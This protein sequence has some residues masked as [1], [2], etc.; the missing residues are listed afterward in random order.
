MALTSAEV[1][2]CNQSLGKIGAKRFT[3]GD[4][5]SNQSIQCLLHFE[6]NRDALLRTFK[7]P[8]AKTRLRLVSAWLTDT[9][10][11]TDQYVWQSSLLYKAAE[12]HTSDV[13]ATDLTAVKWVLVSSVDAWVTA[14]EYA[15]NDLVTTN[16]LLYKALEAHTSDVFATDLAAG[17]WVLSTTKPVNVFGFN[18]DVPANFLRLVQVNSGHVSGHHNHN[19]EDAHHWTLETNTILTDLVEVDI[20]Y[21]DTITTTTEW[22]SL[23]TEFLI[24]TLAFKLLGPLVGMGSAA[25]RLRNEL[26]KELKELRKQ[27]RAVGSDE[28]NNAGDSNW[29]NARFRGRLGVH[30][31]ERF[32]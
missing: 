32:W 15:L 8:F 24:C 1:D 12:A 2:L 18:Y 26:R 27:A 10:Y 31:S 21:V 6:Q 11:S 7:W 28:G 20:V 13:F 16:A 3:F 4:V 30:G 14:T 22:D 9:I 19:H 23:F 5:T 25:I 17:K 29:N